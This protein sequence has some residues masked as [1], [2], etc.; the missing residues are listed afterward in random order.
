[1]M[2]VLQ[3]EGVIEYQCCSEVKYGVDR[4]LTAGIGHL[5][6]PGDLDEGASVEQKRQTADAS[7]FEREWDVCGGRNTESFFKEVCHNGEQRDAT[8]D[9]L[10]VKSKSKCQTH[11]MPT[12]SSDTEVR[13]EISGLSTW[14]LRLKTTK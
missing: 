9:D 3:E 6:G 4:K 1:M 8:T 11:Q 7:E 13:E 14:S 2:K 10:S 5:Q 12:M